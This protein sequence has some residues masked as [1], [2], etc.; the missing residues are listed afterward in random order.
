MLAQS[1]HQIEEYCTFFEVGG[2]ATDKVGGGSRLPQAP[3]L[4]QCWRGLERFIGTLSRQS[5]SLGGCLNRT[6]YPMTM[7]RPCWRNSRWNWLALTRRHDGTNWFVGTITSR[8][9]IWLGSNC[10]MSSPT[11][12]AVGWPY[13]AGARRPCTLKPATNPSSGRTCNGSGGC[14]WWPK[15]AD[16]SFW[17]TGSN[18]PTWLPVA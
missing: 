4:D 8:T 1:K 5:S 3:E 9:P 18:G 16:S 11:P 6:D 10:A 15:T 2:N 14:I 17:P 12:R 7:N 13:W